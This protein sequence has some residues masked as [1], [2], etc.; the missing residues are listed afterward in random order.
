MGFAVGAALVGLIIWLIGVLIFGTLMMSFVSM[1][2]RA[3][4]AP[5]RFDGQG[6]ATSEPIRLAGDA[7][8]RWTASPA[9]DATCR[10]RGVLAPK[11]LAQPTAVIVDQD[12]STQA[13]G[14][15]PLRSLF[16]GDY[17]LATVS[18]CNWSFRIVPTS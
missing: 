16:S 5:Q 2:S 4:S 14:T 11:D 18:T 17:V 7:D 15:Y 9:G 13:D 8:V 12:I 3:T 1:S 6:T 10:L